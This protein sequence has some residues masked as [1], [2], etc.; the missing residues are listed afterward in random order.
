MSKI[1]QNNDFHLI[2]IFENNNNNNISI[3][4]Y[5]IIQTYIENFFDLN[6]NFY[7]QLF[8]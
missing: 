2:F 7:F 1:G 6:I 8:L 3:Y 5:N 4:L